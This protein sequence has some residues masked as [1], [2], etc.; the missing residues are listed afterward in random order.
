MKIKSS[1]LSKTS[2]NSRFAY[3]SGFNKAPLVVND[4]SNSSKYDRYSIFSNKKLNINK[5]KGKLKNEKALG[6][7]FLASPVVF[8]Q[9]HLT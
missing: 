6:F 3:F 5:S 8:D 4:R 9:G 1:L 2:T 7:C